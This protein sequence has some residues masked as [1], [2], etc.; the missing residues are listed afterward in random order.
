MPVS[1]GNVNYSSGFGVVCRREGVAATDAFSAGRSTFELAN[2]SRE[3]EGEDVEDI[4][5]MF[6]DCFW[7]LLFIAIAAYILRSALKMRVRGSL[8]A[9]TCKKSMPC[10]YHTLA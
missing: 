6:L 4:L 1:S 2:H 3:A 10:P 8:E 7:L 5:L 9:A